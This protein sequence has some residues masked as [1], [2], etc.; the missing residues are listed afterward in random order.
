M[1]I[2]GLIV[3]VL[4]S[5]LPLRGQDI[6]TGINLSFQA[7]E[8][9]SLELKNQ[10]RT[11][12][13]FDNDDDQ[14]FSQFGVKYKLLE[15]L[16]IRGFYRFTAELSEENRTRVGGDLLYS[17]NLGK[18]DFK[19]SYRLRYQYSRK[20]KEVVESQDA[21]RN[22]LAILYKFDKLAKPY[23]SM[24]HFHL[25]DRSESPAMRFTLGL[26]SKIMS[27]ASLSVF[28]RIENDEELFN[29]IGLVLKI[30]LSKS[31]FSES[32]PIDD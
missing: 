29:I 23:F 9:A 28:Y 7:T 13:L 18:S 27:A 5:V 21:L 3:I 24:E 4:A 30:K 22:K 12:S 1:R 14:V 25:L 8:K 16:K 20:H 19:F 17:A 15:K 31:M 2:V 32:E 11:E 10:F 26:E 6:W